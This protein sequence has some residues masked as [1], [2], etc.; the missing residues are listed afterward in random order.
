MKR[1][2]LVMSVMVGVV[3]LGGIASAQELGPTFRKIKE[4]I[5]VQSAREVNSTAS[6]V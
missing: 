6:I 2:C 1:C 3:A 5:Y 4:G